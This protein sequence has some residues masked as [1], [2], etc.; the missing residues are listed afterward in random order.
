M[1]W[2]RAIHFAGPVALLLI[3]LRPLARRRGHYTLDRRTAWLCLFGG[4][5]WPLSVVLRLASGFQ[6]DGLIEL[7]DSASIFFGGVLFAY[8]FWALRRV[9]FSL[10]SEGDDWSLK[11]RKSEKHLKNRSHSERPS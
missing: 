5:V 2:E 1:S 10:H 8:G 11:Y 3:S 9:R 7:L 6:A 4:L